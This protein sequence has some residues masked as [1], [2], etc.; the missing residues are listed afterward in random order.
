MT[1]D[2]LSLEDLFLNFAEQTSRRSTCER[3]AVG[4]VLVQDRHVVGHGYNGAPA[5]LPHC[6]EI[7]ADIGA[8]G[9]CARCV[10]AEANAIAWAARR[11]TSLEGAQLYTTHTPCLSCAKLIIACG[12]TEVHSRERYRLPEGVELLTRAG[13]DVFMHD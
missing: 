3:A 8:D 11:G 10:H 5:S 4:A 13:V 9:S 12:I 7:G 1:T 2:R 6:N